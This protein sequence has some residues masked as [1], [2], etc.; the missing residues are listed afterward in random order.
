MAEG[1][2]GQEYFFLTKKFHDPASRFLP[3]L[4]KTKTSLRLSNPSREPSSWLAPL[5]QNIFASLII[6][7]RGGGFASRKKLAAKR[8]IFIIAL[9]F[10]NRRHSSRPDESQTVGFLPSSKFHF[11]LFCWL[12]RLPYNKDQAV[13]GF[14]DTFR[15][16]RNRHLGRGLFI[17]LSY[18]DLHCEDK[19]FLPGIYRLFFEF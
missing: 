11:V 9:L 3:L 19:F 14:S 15:Y 7:R 10:K 16:I 13:K 12:H 2:F 1:G 5:S 4:R 18:A 8:A 17:L 6:L